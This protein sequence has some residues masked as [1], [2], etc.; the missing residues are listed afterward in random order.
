M[1]AKH[2]YTVKECRNG[3]WEAIQDYHSTREDTGSDWALLAMAADTV[4][5]WRERWIEATERS[6]DRKRPSQERKAY[7]ALAVAHETGEPIE[8]YAARKRVKG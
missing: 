3:Y 4:A 6:F 7:A 8:F 2:R 1:A 5:L